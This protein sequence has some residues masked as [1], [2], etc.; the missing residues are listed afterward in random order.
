MLGGWPAS[1]ERLAHYIL[2]E[3]QILSTRIIKPQVIGER[4]EV[5]TYRVA[6]VNIEFIRIDTEP[7]VVLSVVIRREDS[8]KLSTYSD[9]WILFLL[10]PTLQRM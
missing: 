2:P 3:R 9:G 7:D 8:M 4:R 5:V 1:P 6:I 10:S